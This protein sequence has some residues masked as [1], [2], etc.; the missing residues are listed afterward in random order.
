[1]MSYENTHRFLSVRPLVATALLGVLSMPACLDDTSTGTPQATGATSGEATTAGSGG[2]KPQGGS[3]NASG[4]PGDGGNDDGLAGAP[5]GGSAPVAG[6]AP[7]EAGAPNEQPQG[8]AGGA[9]GGTDDEGVKIAPYCTFHTDAPPSETGAG[10]EGPAPEVMMQVSPFVGNYLTDGAGRT[11][12]TYGG[13]VAGDCQTPPQST[14]VADCL[15]S[16]P[17]FHAPARLLGPGLDDAA[18]GEIQLGDGSWQSTY[19]GWPLYYYK[20]DLT[21]GQLTGQGKGKIWH[22]AETTLPSI[23]VMKAGTL[24]YLADAGGHTLY[25]SAADVAGSAEADPESNCSGDCLDTFEAYHVK[26]FSAVTVLE[27]LDFQVFARKGRG[28]LQLSYKGMPLYRAATDVKSGD[29]T[30]T[31]VTGFTAAVP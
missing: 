30:G 11:L 14:C 2:S 25:V 15:V 3:T 18:F 29:M 9:S 21:L 16:W 17:V 26:N 20:A 24:K 8:G 6:N 23:T 12:Y 19:M 1:M 10:G 4:A 22:V 31:A 27:P 7:V 28:G 13:D 5:R